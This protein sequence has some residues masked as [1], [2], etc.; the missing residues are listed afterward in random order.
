MRCVRNGCRQLYKHKQETCWMGD[1]RISQSSGASS[2]LDCC[3]SHC[4]PLRPMGG[5]GERC[6]VSGIELN[7]TS[8]SSFKHS[9]SPSTDTR[10]LHRYMVSWAPAMSWSNILMLDFWQLA[11]L[12]KLSSG[13]SGRIYGLGVRMNKTRFTRY[14]RRDWSTR[15]INCVFLSFFDSSLYSMTLII[16]QA[17][18]GYFKT[19]FVLLLY[20]RIRQY[21]FSNT[22]VKYLPLD[23]AI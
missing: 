6:I 9:Q 8:C 1:E 22:L 5:E 2:W 7:S 20:T 15:C 12:C 16:F 3:R 18:R 14:Y 13:Y 19:I 23:E 11:A 4:I 10:K 21:N 17:Q